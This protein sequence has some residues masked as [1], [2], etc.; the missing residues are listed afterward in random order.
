MKAV[1]KTV[2]APRQDGSFDHIRPLYLEALTLVEATE[3]RWWEAELYRL[4]GE[5]LLR[6]PLLD[7]P[8]ATACFHH[9]LAVARAA[10][11][12]P[13]DD[14]GAQR[15][16]EVEGAQGVQDLEGEVAV[17]GG[18]S[19]Q[20]ESGSM[21]ILSAAVRREVAITAR[22]AGPLI[23]GQLAYLGMAFVDTVMAG[24][25]SAETLAAVAL[26]GSV[27]SSLHLFVLG[28]LLALP[29]F[30]SEYEGRESP[31][32]RARIAPFARQVGWVAVGLSLLAVLVAV[33]LAPLLEAVGIGAEL[34]P[35][36]MDYL[37]ALA[38]GI[39]AWSLYLVLRFLS[40]GLS[41]SR[42]TLYFG[43]LGL[44]VNALANYALMYGHFGFPPLGAA[45]CGGAPKG[46]GRLTHKATP[47][48]RE[49]LVQLY[50]P[51]AQDPW[52]FASVLM[53][54]ALA[55]DEPE[56]RRRIGAM[57]DL[58]KE[59]K[60]RALGSTSERAW[61]VH[62]PIRA[63]PIHWPKAIRLTEGEHPARQGSTTARHHCPRPGATRHGAPPH[64]LHLRRWL[65]HPRKSH[66]VSRR[67][68]RHPAA[69]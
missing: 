43:V 5:L 66:G 1:A 20:V 14:D 19:Y 58:L 29:P 25:L 68:V 64:P 6:L 67:R 11:A 24:N 44:P 36:V 16:E 26:G 17:H 57:A 10:G 23:G 63:K 33:S 28:V 47:D 7:I 31:E 35:V 22:L 52:A 34:T 38:W 8:Q 54:S 3:E 39:P 59:G 21:I 27:F 50:V 15:G 45:G 69:D 49:A 32:A 65:Q 42:P 2:E 37:S 30:V 60:V 41:L 46:P 62:L 48:E 61:S 9:A 18:R 12:Q 51:M 55:L 13:A 40:E 53:S 4:K 56:R